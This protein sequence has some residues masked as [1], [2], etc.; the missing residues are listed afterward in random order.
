MSQDHH[1][2]SQLEPNHGLNVPDEVAVGGLRSVLQS[3]APVAVDNVAAVAAELPLLLQPVW[4][5]LKSPG[6]R[7]S[8]DVRPETSAGSLSFRSQEMEL[9]QV[10]KLL[11]VMDKHGKSVSIDDL[12]AS[13][14]Q[15]I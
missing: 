10:E 14:L 13:I 5:Q 4:R 11:K 3:A 6:A 2:H 1:R 12:S 8:G 15:P 9:V 7:G